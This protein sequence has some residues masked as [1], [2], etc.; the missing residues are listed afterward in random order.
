[1]TRELQHTI[2]TRSWPI[3]VLRVFAVTSYLLASGQFSVVPLAGH[4]LAARRAASG[5][6]QGCAPSTPLAPIDVPFVVNSTLLAYHQPSFPSP[7]S[8]PIL[9][10]A[11]AAS[12]SADKSVQVKLVLLGMPLFLLGSLYS[13]T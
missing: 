8:T 7:F 12:G 3:D 10:M 13:P 1:M 4:E 2:S 6:Q 9:Q 11:D 5:P